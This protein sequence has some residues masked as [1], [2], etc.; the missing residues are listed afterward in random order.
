M[1]LNPVELPSKVKIRDVS[2]TPQ[3]GHFLQK[4]D[5]LSSHSYG[6]SIITPF[7]LKATNFT[8]YILEH[9]TLGFLFK[10]TPVSIQTTD[11]A[12]VAEWL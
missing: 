3:R 11:L 10:E 4:T 12:Q 6:L 2:E 7:D 1:T 5:W 8:E 9:S